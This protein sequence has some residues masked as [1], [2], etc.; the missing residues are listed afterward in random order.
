MTQE[1]INKIKEETKSQL[2]EEL[3]TVETKRKQ[4]S[5]TKCAYPNAT[6]YVNNTMA[7]CDICVDILKID[8]TE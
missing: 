6:Q 5:C 8:F 7:Y 3:N 4:L 2:F 1:Q